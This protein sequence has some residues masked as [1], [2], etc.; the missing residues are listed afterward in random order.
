M[1]ATLEFKPD[2]EQATARWLAFWNKELIDR[3]CCVI[4]APKDPAKPMPPAPPYMAGAREIGRAH[5]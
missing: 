4:T 5:V 2:L 3:P 1:G